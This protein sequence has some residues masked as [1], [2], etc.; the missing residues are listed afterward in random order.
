[1][2][3]DAE[4][5]LAKIEE[6]NRAR[7]K[8]FMEKAKEQ[9]KKQISAIISGEAHATLC[10]IRDNSTQAGETVSFGQIIERALAAYVKTN[11]SINDGISQPKKPREQ[12]PVEAPALV[13]PE[14]QTDIL[15]GIDPE[16]ISV[17][18]RDR[19]VL[20]LYEQFPEKKQAKDRIKALNDAGIFFNGEPWTTKQYSDQL[21][22]AR[23]RQKS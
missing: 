23:K 21:N 9:G 3:T 16:N 12:E 15:E 13:E 4:K 1:M 22:L 17:E 8:R 2:S 14:T 11:V 5:K 6:Q 18:D 19:L 7:V 10:R 20:K